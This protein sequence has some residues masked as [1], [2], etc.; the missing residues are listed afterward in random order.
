MNVLSVFGLLFF[1]YVL[2]VNLWLFNVFWEFLIYSLIFEGF[3]WFFIIFS[4]R[5]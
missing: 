4:I 3:I 5:K 2:V 1:R